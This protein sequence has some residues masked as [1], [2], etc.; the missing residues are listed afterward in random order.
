[1]AGSIRRGLQ[2]SWGAPAGRLSARSRLVCPEILD[3]LPA[4]DPRAIR[5]R[6]DL[7]RVNRAVGSCAILTQTARHA[8]ASASTPPL[9]RVL[10]LGAGDGS[11][12][13]RIAMRLAGSWPTAELTLLDRQALVDE[14]TGTAFAHLGW[15]LR[16]LTVDV[17]EWARAPTQQQRSGRWHLVLA[18]LFLHHF[19]EDA[20]GE[21]LSAIAQ[22]CDAFIA[23]EP[24]RSTAALIGSRLLPALGVSADTRHDATVSVRAGFRGS[25]L[26]RMWPAAA[27]HWRLDERSRGLFSH[28]FVAVRGSA[29]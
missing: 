5:S 2:L 11:M 25:E 1:M 22:R 24:R 9:L 28:L 27:D 20:L 6:R 7:R 14:K 12:A 13:L 21:L 10:E 29:G 23:C 16:P 3:Q 15:T 17:L 26:S 18:N 19:E 4:M 8:L